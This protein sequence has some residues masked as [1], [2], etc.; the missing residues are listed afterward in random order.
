M[1]I[2]DSSNTLKICIA[3]QNIS[4][5]KII[6]DKYYGTP[7]LQSELIISWFFSILV[8]YTQITSSTIWR[9]MTAN[10]TQLIFNIVYI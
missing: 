1:N 4:K 7:I 10:N 2:Y 6:T 3:D 5:I 9:M 8:E